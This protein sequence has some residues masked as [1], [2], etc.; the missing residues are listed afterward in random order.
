MRAI[1]DHVATED[2][3]GPADFDSLVR[4]LTPWAKKA[5]TDTRDAKIESKKQ[6]RAKGGFRVIGA[7]SHTRRGMPV[8][9]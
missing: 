1:Q 6:E 4:H 9:D 7:G 2:L 5:V 8:G 3:R